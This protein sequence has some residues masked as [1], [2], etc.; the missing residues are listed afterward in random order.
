MA[1]LKGI[2][3]SHW[4]GTI[5]WKKVAKSYS[6][7]LIKCTEGTGYIDPT[8]KT[9]LAGA[10]KNGLVVGSYHFARGID[11]VK[12]ADFY[13]KNADL[14][15]GE[16]LTLD[17]EI[18]IADSVGF[19]TKFVER[20][21]EK[22]GFWPFFYSYSS[23]AATF[24]SG[25]VLNCGLWIADPSSKPRIGAWKTWAI[26]QYTIAPAGQT[27]GM[28]TSCDQDYFNG[29]LEQLKKYGKQPVVI[30]EPTPIPVPTPPVT[31]EPE[32]PVSLPVP[33]E[34]PPVATPSWIEVFAAFLA[35]LFRK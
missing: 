2:D 3:C 29:S 31:I 30:P 11:P 21:K 1:Y 14:R 28:T 22:A 4:Q 13:L 15:E 35:N 12:E 6:F 7:A 27:P 5:D 25:S 33:H 32:F 24:K 23:M 8:Y 17:F 18:K 9:N 26:W 10:R 34:D 20:I 19:C 16:L